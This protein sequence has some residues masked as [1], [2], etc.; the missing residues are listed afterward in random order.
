MSLTLLLL[1]LMSTDGQAIE[2][3][4]RAIEAFSDK[5]KEKAFE[6]LL[7]AQKQTTDAEVLAKIHR[8]RGIF[9]EVEGRALESVIA[10]MKA[11]SLNAGIQLPSSVRTSTMQRRFSCAKTLHKSGKDE[12][13]VRAHYKVSLS[14]PP[15]QCVVDPKPP[16]KTKS[17]QKPKPK[18]GSRLPKAPKARGASFWPWVSVG[19]AG[20]AGAFGVGFGLSARS[21]LGVS[22][23]DASYVTAYGTAEDRILAA[24]A[25]WGI[26]GAAA[27]TSAVLFILDW[28]EVFGGSASEAPPNSRELGLVF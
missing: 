13:F 14:R 25:A 4:A 8:Q 2:T 20:V 23:A 11:L 10:F 18:P 27:L 3:M 6:L 5:Q 7:Q 12:A 17:E 16:P 9:F 1:A 22:P 26:A 28:A 15:F 19:V 21:A 24:N